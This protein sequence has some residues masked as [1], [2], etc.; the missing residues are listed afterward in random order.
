MNNN[1]EQPNLMADLDRL[2][3]EEKKERQSSI[4]GNLILS[5]ILPPFS[6]LWVLYR[7]WK[8]KALHLLLP[9]MTILYS[10]LFGFYS[11]LM[12]SSPKAFTAVFAGK[13]ENSANLPKG[14]NFLITILAIL[15]TVAGI[16]GGLYTRN[17]AKREDRLS[18]SMILLLVVILVLQFWIS[19]RELTWVSSV[20]NGSLGDLYEG[21]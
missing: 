16:I 19:F 9:T 2:I 20:I 6:T 17:K 3:T 10:I 12:L 15:L 8:N 18:T 7:A 21:L 13:I 5:L 14:Q 1:L 11:Y 4:W